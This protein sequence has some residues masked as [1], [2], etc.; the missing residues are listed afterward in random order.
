M[1]TKKTTPKKTTAKKTTKPVSA[2]K[3]TV[4]KQTATPIKLSNNAK[5]FD[6]ITGAFDDN[7]LCELTTYFPEGC[8]K[9]QKV[10]SQEKLV[11]FITGG[12]AKKAKFKINVKR[13]DGATKVIELTE[14]LLS[15]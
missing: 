3:T 8:M 1:P 5:L 4:K 11:E 12:L 2:K 6:S 10:K 13:A 9:R 7:A 14:E 15:E